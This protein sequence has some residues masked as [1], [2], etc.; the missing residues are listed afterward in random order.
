MKIIKTRKRTEVEITI[1]E[2]Q[3]MQN[4]ARVVT[5]ECA[6]D[7][8]KMINSPK[9][10]VGVDLAEKGSEDKDCMVFCSTGFKH[11]PFHFAELK[12]DDDI[13]KEEREKVIEEALRILRNYSEFYF[14]KSWY[15]EIKELKN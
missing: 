10:F 11:N 2:I 5:R 7:I 4:S 15:K 8:L 3:E 9:V 6:N 1:T 14:Q 12:T 13:R